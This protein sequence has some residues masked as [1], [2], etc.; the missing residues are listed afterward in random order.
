MF[1]IRTVIHVR[2]D[3]LLRTWQLAHVG[4]CACVGPGRAPAV[5]TVCI[6][7]P[8]LE[9]VS[10]LPTPRAVASPVTGRVTL[11]AV[12]HSGVA[13][14]A[15]PNAYIVVVRAH[16][17]EVAHVCEMNPLVYL[18]FARRCQILHLGLPG[19]GRGGRWLVPCPA[20]HA[21]LWWI[22]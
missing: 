1:L 14:A 3:V 9:V 12:L 22:Q 8:L 4:R 21:A 19:D 11:L 2:S 15:A 13:P 17:P 5:P 7:S 20:A 16:A 6:A 10:S 18:S